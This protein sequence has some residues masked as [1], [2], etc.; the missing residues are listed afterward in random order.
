MDVTTG[1]WI[2]LEDTSYG[3]ARH[4]CGIIET[5]EGVPEAVVAGGYGA[6]TS[7]EIFSFE[8][9]TWREGPEMPKPVDS[10]AR[11]GDTKFEL[12]FFNCEYLS[13][14]YG[15]TF[16]VIGGHDGAS[17]GELYYDS[18]LQFDLRDSMGW[19]EREEKMETARAWHNAVPLP[20]ETGACGYS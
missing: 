4:A 14:Q 3:R 17:S 20:E 11:C 15:D 5:E 2:R 7:V 1:G 10:A 19:F 9:M 18:V 16:L 8:T 12:I 13:L 6:L